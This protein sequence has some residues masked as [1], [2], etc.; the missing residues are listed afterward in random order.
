M[1]SAQGT[2]ARRIA[3]VQV[4]RSDAGTTTSGRDHRRA[5]GQRDVGLSPSHVVGEQAAAMAIEQ[6]VR[7]ALPTRTGRGAA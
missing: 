2:P 6:G 1:T 4:D 5:H 7:R 3:S